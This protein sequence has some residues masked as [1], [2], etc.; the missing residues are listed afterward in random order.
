MTDTT[1]PSSAAARVVDY[2]SRHRRAFHDLNVEWITTYFGLEEA[3][4]R[5]L[6]DPEGTILR[7]GGAILMAEEGDRIVG[8]CALLRIEPDVYELAKMAVTPT[9][10]GKGI[11]V[12][13]GRAA[14]R[15]A[16]ELGA[17]RIELV[18]NTALRPALGVYRK[19]GFVEAPLGSSEYARA[20]IRMVLTLDGSYP[21]A[22]R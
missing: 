22:E 6:D 16:R 14:V 19:L 21:A 12:L 13:L 2:E 3:D 5:V 17:R 7:E 15:R 11:G 20:D 18:S 10:R 4:R 1:A 9:A 8:C